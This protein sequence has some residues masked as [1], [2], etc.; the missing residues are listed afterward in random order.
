MAEKAEENAVAIA[1]AEEEEEEI[2]ASDRE[3]EEG[4][5]GGSSPVKPAAKSP[6]KKKK[7]SNAG[8]QIPEHWPWEEAKKVF[9][10]PEVVKADDM[11]V[12]LFTTTDD[13]G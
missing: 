13:M 9:L 11:D 12:S 4:G 2:V 7:V 1:E 10:N 6:K 5:G 8:M 3:S